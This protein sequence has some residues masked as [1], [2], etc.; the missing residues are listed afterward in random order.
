[1]NEGPDD[2]HRKAKRNET[3]GHQSDT[4]LKKP[5]LI[6]ECRS[7]EHGSTST[8][9]SLIVGVLSIFEID[10]YATPGMSGFSIM[11]DNL[12]GTMHVLS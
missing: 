8:A 2:I 12:V 7:S 1:M 6:T 4:H 3:N 11:Y 9:D 5:L 10:S